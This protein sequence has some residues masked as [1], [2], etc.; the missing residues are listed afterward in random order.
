MTRVP[1]GP[2]AGETMARGGVLLTLNRASVLKLRRSLIC[3]SRIF[4]LSLD[5]MEFHSGG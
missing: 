4:C 1:L 5:I 3:E 2:T